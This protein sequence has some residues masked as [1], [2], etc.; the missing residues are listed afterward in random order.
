MCDF[1][2][3]GL[4]SQE[5]NSVKIRMLKELKAKR[6]LYLQSVGKLQIES[7]QVGFNVVQ[8]ELEAHC[9]NFGLHMKCGVLI[10]FTVV[11]KV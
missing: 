4:K 10:P 9:H 7:K 5:N 2:K 8:L 1:L 11:F 3:V 6:K